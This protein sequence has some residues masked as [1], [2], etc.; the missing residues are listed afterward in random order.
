MKF[1]PSSRPTASRLGPS[2][3]QE[4]LG[5][6]ITRELPAVKVVAAVNPQPIPTT[7]RWKV[8]LA[9]WVKGWTGGLLCSVVWGCPTC[10]RVAEAALLHPATKLPWQLINLAGALS[11][12]HW[13]T[14]GGWGQGGGTSGLLQQLKIF[15]VG[16]G[17]IYIFCW[18]FSWNWVAVKTIGSVCSSVYIDVYFDWDVCLFHI[19]FPLMYADTYFSI[20]LFNIR[21]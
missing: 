19:D 6:P 7:L 21:F 12:P 1:L 15:A 11:R 20:S 13:G 4:E 3:P 14:E 8:W 5:S 2:T 17:G 9:R 16:C 10:G 18:K